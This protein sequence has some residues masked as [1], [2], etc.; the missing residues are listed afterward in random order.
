MREP[1]MTPTEDAEIERPSASHSVRFG[2]DQRI[3]KVMLNGRQKW[4]IK[5]RPNHG[6]PVW[7]RWDK[8]GVPYTH[9]EVLKAEGMKP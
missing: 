7:E 1:L 2:W 4:E 8:P 9:T 5:E 6:E 3:R